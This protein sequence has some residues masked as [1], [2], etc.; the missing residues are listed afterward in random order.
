MKRCDVSGVFS[1]D[2]WT[3]MLYTKK[4]NIRFYLIFTH[5]KILDWVSGNSI[6]RTRD[7]VRGKYA[8][9]PSHVDGNRVRYNIYKIYRSNERSMLHQV[10][11]QGLYTT[12]N[13]HTLMMD[14]PVRTVALD[15]A[16]YKPR[17]GRRFIVG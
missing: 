11:I 8:F 9:S 16:Y 14:V 6:R 3:T 10:V 2:V 15:P 4:Q 17:S 12:E 7:Y 13:S 5:A 1:E